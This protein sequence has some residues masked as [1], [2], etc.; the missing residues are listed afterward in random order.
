MSKFQGVD[1]YQVDALL[2]EDELLVRN[3]VREFVEAAPTEVDAARLTHSLATN[4][5]RVRRILNNDLSPEPA[6]PPGKAPQLC[7]AC[8]Y[9][10]VFEALRRKDCIVAGDIG[11]YSLG[12]LEPFVGHWVLEF[13]K[14]LNI[15]RRL[16][17][18]G[19]N[20][21]ERRLLLPRLRAVPGTRCANPLSVMRLTGQPEPTWSPSV[22]A[23]TLAESF[24]LPTR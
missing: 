23:L 16:L 5:P 22:V 2:T 19:R 13:R 17:V 1:Y 8:Q 14:R 9:R 3:T 7:D 6:K 24:R 4:V 18:V 11:C 15:F 12:V 20:T 10:I 21:V